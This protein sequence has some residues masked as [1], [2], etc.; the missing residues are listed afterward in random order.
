[1]HHLQE[2]K[3]TE[4]HFLLFYSME[5]YEKHPS[6]ILKPQCIQAGS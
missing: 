6:M 1:M 3:R 5:Y 4:K 2:K